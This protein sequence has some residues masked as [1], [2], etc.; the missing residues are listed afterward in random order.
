MCSSGIWPQQIL[1]ALTTHEVAFTLAGTYAA[2]MDRS[3]IDTYR[4]LDEAYRGLAD[5]R[6]FLKSRKCQAGPAVARGAA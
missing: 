3:V 5:L 2:I 4:E 6:S 1:A